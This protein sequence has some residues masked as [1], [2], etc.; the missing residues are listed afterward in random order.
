[1]IIKTV[2]V[3]NGADLFDLESSIKSKKAD[4]Y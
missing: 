1:M 3:L 4:L 2:N